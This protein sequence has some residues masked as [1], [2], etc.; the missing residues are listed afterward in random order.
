MYY[1]SNEEEFFNFYR[2]V[3]EKIRPKIYIGVLGGG[4]QHIFFL[5]Y[6]RITILIDLNLKQIEYIKDYRDKDCSYISE[7]HS[8]YPIFP[9]YV[10]QICL[11]YGDVLKLTSEEELINADI[12]KIP[13]RKADLIYLSNVPDYLL[14]KFYRR[15]EYQEGIKTLVKKLEELLEIS[16]YI[17]F[18]NMYTHLW[19]LYSKLQRILERKYKVVRYKDAYVVGKT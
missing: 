5:K 11:K 14:D 17:L 12:W 7:K 3:A 18:V 10:Y 13:V 8:K 9:E 19:F 2:R 6:S 1:K 15:R 4:T 16:N